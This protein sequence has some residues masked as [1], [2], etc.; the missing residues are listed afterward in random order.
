VNILLIGIFT[1]VALGH[2]IVLFF[3][4]KMLQAISKICLLPL[5][6]GI[7]LV[8]AEHFIFTVVLAA[9]FGWG[10]DVLLLKID[11]R[12]FFKG[13]LTC[14]LLG[15]LCYIPSMFFFTRT[16]HIPGLIIS[17]AAAFPLALAVMRFI[18]PPKVMLIP[19]I[20]YGVVIELMVI[21][22]LQLALYRRDSIGLVIFGGSLCFLFS[23]TILAR[24]SF[25]TL[26]KYGS[27][28]VM[29]PYILAQSS[30]ILGLTQ[31]NI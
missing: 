12:V 27:F 7:Y 1:A 9:I 30:I 29:L 10:G 13:G 5:L 3:N 20:I 28:F 4:N 17:A 31:A 6:L 25:R 8:S 24:F 19:V 23:D 21:S 14:F 18:R 26:P 2:L 15:H 11:N 16:V 22:A